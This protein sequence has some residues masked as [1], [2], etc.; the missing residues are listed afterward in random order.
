MQDV[1]NVVKVAIKTDQIK[2]LQF[3]SI[4]LN[5]TKPN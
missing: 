3:F 5:L 1:Q 4:Q 2:S